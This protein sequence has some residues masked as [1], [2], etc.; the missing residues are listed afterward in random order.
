VNIN[1]TLFRQ[2][3]SF[4]LFACFCMRYVWPP[5]I[6]AMEERQNRIAAGL[7][8]AEESRRLLDKSKAS[9]D[10]SLEEA[11]RQAAQLIEQ[12]NKRA[13]QII[14][15]AKERARAEG[16]KIKQAAA[17]EISLEVS[18]AKNA[19]R[20]H[21]SDLVVRGAEKV[22]GAGVDRAKHKDLLESLISEL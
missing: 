21:V 17:N 19:L 16:D 22:V 3:I 15:D 1:L 13:L 20:A 5:L 9:V 18:K 8:D 2:L 14:E 10:Q 6:N 4:I 11:K 12:A 7:R